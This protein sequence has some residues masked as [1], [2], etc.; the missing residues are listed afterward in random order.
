MENITAPWAFTVVNPDNGA[1]IRGGN[2][3]FKEGAERCML[4]GEFG[5]LLLGYGVMAKGRSWYNFASKTWEVI[6]KKPNDFCKWDDDD[7]LWVDQRELA[8]YKAQ[9]L[10]TINSAYEA[11]AATMTA[12]YPATEVAT[13]PNQQR[14]AQA[15]EADPTAATPFLDEMAEN[16][17]ID[18]GEL[19]AKTLVN[20]KKYLSAVARFTGLRQRLRDEIANAS[21]IAEVTAV[22][23]PCLWPWCV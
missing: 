9:Q 14:E 2:A 4:P 18:R 10:V 5:T 19:L 12:G 17:G 16:R 3:G 15:W 22:Q 1:V 8:D 11:A 20:V 21:T 23:W 7:H 6:P 13:W